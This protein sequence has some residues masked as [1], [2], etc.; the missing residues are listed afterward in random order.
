MLGERNHVLCVVLD[1]NIYI[2]VNEEDKMV[3]LVCANII[4]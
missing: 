2:I 1:L 3:F 4:R